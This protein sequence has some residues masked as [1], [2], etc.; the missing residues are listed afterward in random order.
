MDVDFT[1]IS[2]SPPD[3]PPSTR[4]PDC[5]IRYVHC[6]H[7]E[8][9]AVISPSRQW[10]HRLHP[11]QTHARTHT[12]T[13]VRIRFYIV[14]RRLTS[15]PQR[16]GKTQSWIR[17]INSKFVYLRQFA[18]RVLERGMKNRNFLRYLCCDFQLLYETLGRHFLIWT[19]AR[20]LAQDW[21]ISKE[22]L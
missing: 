6:V 14:P 20:N 4:V 10:L 2:S 17:N 22:D 3:D 21:S 7:C 1:Y 11:L 16:Q 12:H 8:R 5:N 15:H 18:S 9:T 13:H 19:R